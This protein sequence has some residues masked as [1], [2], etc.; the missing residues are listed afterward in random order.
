MKMS[1]IAEELEQAGIAVTY[2]NIAVYVVFVSEEGLAER[3]GL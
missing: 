1:Q 2:E 3:L